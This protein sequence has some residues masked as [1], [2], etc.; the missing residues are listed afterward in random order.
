MYLTKRTNGIWYL[1]YTKPDGKEKRVSTGTTQ[2]A[3]AYQFLRTY[4]EKKP[5][6]KMTLSRFRDEF[7]SV[8]KSRY[9]PSTLA[10]HF[11]Y[12]HREF[13]KFLGD[14]LLVEVTPMDIERFLAHK[15]TTNSIWNV[16][17]LYNA[18][19][20]SYQKAVIW[21]YLEQNPFRKVKK[22]PAVPLPPRY[23]KPDE[24]KSLLDAMGDR[25]IRNV[26]IFSLAT[27]LRLGEVVSLKW[28]AVSLETKTLVVGNPE[29]FT[30]KTK[31]NRSPC[32]APSHCGGK[33]RGEGEGLHGTS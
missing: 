7:L 28:E 21:G 26:C 32:I 30:T 31:K 18:L 8:G 12:A 2:K 15:S 14:V 5:I 9:A 13:I 22:P 11:S 10:G 23:L 33:N 27:G 20:S 29:T 3:Q 16:R 6:P 4:A 17:T 24:V 1:A 19:A 25:R